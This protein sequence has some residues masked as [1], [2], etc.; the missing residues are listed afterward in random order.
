MFNDIHAEFDDL[1]SGYS[2][3]S[4]NKAGE[5]GLKRPMVNTN[6]MNQLKYA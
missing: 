2:T 1:T 6:A 5:L 4:S 3:I